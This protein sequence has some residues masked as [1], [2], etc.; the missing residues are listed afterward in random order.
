M[1][2]ILPFLSAQ[3]GWAWLALAALFLAGELVTGSG[4]LLW[5]SA[6][7]GATGLS[8]LA[9]APLPLAWQIGLFAGLTVATTLAARRWLPRRV[10]P[11]GLDINDIR[12]RLI[13]H[14]GEGV[15]AQSASGGDGGR[16]ASLAGGGR[17]FIDGKEWAAELVGGGAPSAGQRVRVVEVI[18]AARLKVSPI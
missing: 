16:A 8:V 18:G 15:A 11:A 9:G 17:V 13:G 3:P 7:A 12:T 2:A 14:E 4:Y 6:S 10:R 1:A 5:P